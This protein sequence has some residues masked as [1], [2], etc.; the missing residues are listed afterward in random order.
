MAERSFCP[1]L[2][3]NAAGVTV[4]VIATPLAIGFAIASGVEPSRGLWTAIIAGVM[5]VVMGGLRSMENSA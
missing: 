2:I 1:Q 3:S 5:L 4:R